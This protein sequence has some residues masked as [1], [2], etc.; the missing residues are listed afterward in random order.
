MVLFLF[1]VMLM[2]LNA[3]SEP[4]KN[5]YLLYGGSIAGGCLLLILVAALKKST[6]VSAPI[7]LKFGTIGLVKN[8]GMV[9]FTNYVFA[10]EIS[11]VLFLSAMIGA[12]IIAKKEN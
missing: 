11:S 2:N 12:V 5:K 3:E 4:V 8:L 6:D 1:V 7:Q 9:L 10:F